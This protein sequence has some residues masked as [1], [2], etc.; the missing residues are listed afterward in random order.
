MFTHVLQSKFFFSN[1][2]N[3]VLSTELIMWIDQ[4]N[5]FLKLNFLALAFYHLSYNLLCKG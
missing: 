3:L 4:C 5:K 1:E 2:D